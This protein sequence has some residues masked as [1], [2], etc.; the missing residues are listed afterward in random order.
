MFNNFFKALAI[1]FGR[2][3]FNSVYILE[4]DEQ[5]IWN[6]IITK[7]NIGYIEWYNKT[8]GD[9]LCGAWI[10]DITPKEIRL[11]DKIYNKFYGD[12]WYVSLPLA[13]AQVSYSQYNNIKNKIITL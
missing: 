11:I 8:N 10:K 9:D 1:F 6:N 2:D 5:E 4:Q 12:D 7:A 3:F 13:T